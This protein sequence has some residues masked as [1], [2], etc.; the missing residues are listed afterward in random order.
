MQRVEESPWTPPLLP[1]FLLLSLPLSFSFL[2]ISTSESFYFSSSRY[3]FLLPHLLL[4]PLLL[5]S[6]PSLFFILNYSLFPPSLLPC[7]TPLSSSIIFFSSPLP[8]VCTVSFFW[9]LFV[10]HFSI[11]SLRRENGREAEKDGAGGRRKAS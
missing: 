2:L 6:S 3:R 9:V 8:L 10:F 1:S 11:L 4:L 5:S 7:L